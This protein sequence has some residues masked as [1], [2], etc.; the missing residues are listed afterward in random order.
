MTPKRRNKTP[1][2]SILRTHN[3]STVPAVHN[4]RSDDSHGC[5]CVTHSERKTRNRNRA[6]GVVRAWKKAVISLVR[7]AEYEKVSS[8]MFL[9]TLAGV[10][11]VARYFVPGLGWDPCGVT[12]GSRSYDDTLIAEFLGFD[13]G[14]QRPARAGSVE[15]LDTLERYCHMFLMTLR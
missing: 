14:A 10:R 6:R 3:P 11:L 7:G 4:P 12:R 8:D 9:Q 2:L 1:I 5:G 15:G 13:Y